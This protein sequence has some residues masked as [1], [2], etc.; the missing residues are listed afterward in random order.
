[1]HAHSYTHTDLKPENILL[2]TDELKRTPH[3][4]FENYLLPASDQVKL[5]DFGGAT[6]TSERHSSI[7][8][9]RQ[10]RSPEVIL[11]CCDWRESS[12]VWSIGC[13]VPELYT[14]NLLFATHDDLEHLLMMLKNSQQDKLPAWMPKRCKNDLTKVFRGE[15]IDERVANKRIKNW[16]DIIGFKR[17]DEIFSEVP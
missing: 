15:E 6:H 5:I 8:N 14:G 3:E 16:E 1:M 12:D 4:Q 2:L 7:I 17:V 11:Q 9:T 10:Y 13:I